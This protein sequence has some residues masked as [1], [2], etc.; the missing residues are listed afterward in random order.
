MTT[1]ARTGRLPDGVT[2][3]SLRTLPK[4]LLTREGHPDSSTKTD[5]ERTKPRFREI[6][7]WLAAKAKRRLPRTPRA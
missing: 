6:W 4:E 2:L 5:V 3:A 1:R 7:T